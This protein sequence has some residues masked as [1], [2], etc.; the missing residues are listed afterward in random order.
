MWLIPI[1]DGGAA[2]NTMA[3]AVAPSDAGN[4]AQLRAFASPYVSRGGLRNV[5]LMKT[6]TMTDAV[7]A[8]PPRNAKAT[9]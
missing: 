8:L 7:S 6:A 3:E 5:S 4:G 9:V 2:V 1:S